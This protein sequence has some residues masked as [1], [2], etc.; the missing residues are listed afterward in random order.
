MNGLWLSYIPALGTIRSTCYILLL[1]NCALFQRHLRWCRTALCFSASTLGSIKGNWKLCLIHTQ[2]KLHIYLAKL[3]WE[4]GY[5]VTDRIIYNHFISFLKYIWN[6][7]IIFQVLFHF[8]Y[9]SN[10]ELSFITT[11]RFLCYT[12][13]L[14]LTNMFIHSKEDIGKIPKYNV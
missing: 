9:K 11:L 4:E 13:H 14:I 6:N 8:F 2:E 12:I 7:K 3:N 5:L 1:V 10:Y